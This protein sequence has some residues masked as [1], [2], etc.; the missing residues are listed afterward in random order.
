MSPNQLNIK[1]L[2]KNNKNLRLHF[3]HVTTFVNQMTPIIVILWK[4]N[5][6]LQK[7]SKYLKIRKIGFMKTGYSKQKDRLRKIKPFWRANCISI[8]K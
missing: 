4:E 7:R 8:D 6:N 5:K 1:L 2:T 3:L